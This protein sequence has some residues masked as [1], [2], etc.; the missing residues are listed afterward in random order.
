MSATHRYSTRSHTLPDLIVVPA[1]NARARR[2]A[3]TGLIRA[4]RRCAALRRVVVVVVQLL[5]WRRR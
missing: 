5:C 3:T 2:F 4:R 1:D